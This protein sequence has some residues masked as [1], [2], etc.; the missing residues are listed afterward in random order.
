MVLPG[1]KLIVVAAVSLSIAGCSVNLKGVPRPGQ[2]SLPGER[3]VVS[4]QDELA[5]RVKPADVPWLNHDLIAL[6]IELTN[7]R[8]SGVSLDSKDVVLLD[9][10]GLTH[11]C[12]RPERMTNWFKLAA[13]ATAAAPR[14]PVVVAAGF[15]YGPVHHRYHP[16]HVGRYG[17]HRGRR[18]YH[19]YGYWWRYPYYWPDYYYWND[20]W[21]YDQYERK[22]VARFLSELWAS[23][24]VP[25]DESAI[26][27][28]VFRHKLEKDEHVRVSLTV[29]PEP[30]ATQPAATTQ[31]SPTVFHFEF[32]GG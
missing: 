20:Y 9:E 17:H 14:P 3:G 2:I 21:R 16:Y 8:G 13:E 24:S 26:G 11:S 10:K 18:Y 1:S 12:V 15:S 30:T 28:V 22:S 4:V 7:R 6:T 32:V 27:H 25:P 31:W 23:E 5:V 29:R 19:H